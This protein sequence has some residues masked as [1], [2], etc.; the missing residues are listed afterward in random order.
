MPVVGY[1]GDFVCEH[2][3]ELVLVARCAHQPRVQADEAA[4]EREGI[5]V[6]VPDH[7]EREAVRALVRLAR[8]ALA[9]GL[10]VLD[11]LRILDDLALLAQAAQDHQ[12]DPVFV[13]LGQLRGGGIADVGQVAG[14]VLR[15]PDAGGAPQAEEQQGGEDLAHA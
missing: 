11:D 14:R 7:E 9:Q 3:R 6:G 5:D 1:V 4:G 2:A 15:E 12:T 10:H 13:G 8:E